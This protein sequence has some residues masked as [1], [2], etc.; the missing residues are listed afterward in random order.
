MAKR[1][2]QIIRWP[3]LVYA[4]SGLT[5]SLAVHVISLAG[6]QPFGGQ[7]LFH[8]MNFGV[9]PLFLLAILISAT[10]NEGRWFDLSECPTWIRYMTGVLFIYAFVFFI[11]DPGSERRLTLG[12]EWRLAVSCCSSDGL[13]PLPAWRVFSSGSMLFYSMG[14]AMLASTHGKN[15]RPDRP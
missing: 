4:A 9:F 6:L 12:S 13:P 2:I 11:M 7:S 15:K 10:L 14:L 8:A 1:L 5:L 3:L